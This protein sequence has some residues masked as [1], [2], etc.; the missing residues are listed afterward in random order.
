LL[1]LT[2]VT[3]VVEGVLN[4]GGGPLGNSSGEGHGSGSEDSEDG[5]ETHG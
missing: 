3:E 5:R 2:L 1:L 4:V